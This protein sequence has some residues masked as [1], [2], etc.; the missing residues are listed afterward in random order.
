M[1]IDFGRAARGIATGYL[2]A[3]VAD[4]AAQD[5]LN[6]EFILQ[7]T[8][9]YFNVD[10]P[11]FVAD[12]K[13][14]SANI[15]FIATKLSPVYANYADA[16]NITLSDVNTR[17]FISSIND[18]SNEDKFKLESTITQRKKTRTQTFDEKNKFITDQ[19]ANL[20]GGPGSMNIT[21]MF[22]PNEGQDIAEVGVKQDVAPTTEM[23]SIMEIEGTGGMYDFNNT[24]HR[25][26]ERIGAT[27]FNQLFFDRNTQRF[28]FAI[29]GDKN[30]QGDFVDS[31]YPTVQLLKQGYADAVKQGYE[32]GFEV[33]ARDKF[34]QLVMD[35]RGIKG[36]TG[37]LP[38]EAPAVEAG[39]TEA[40]ATTTETKAVPEDNKKFDAPDTS[41]IGVK[42]DAKINIL[43]K[44]PLEGGGFGSAAT[45]I[46]DLR[47]II[48]RISDSPSLSDDEKS[49]RID[50]ARSRAKERLEA[51]GLDPDNFNL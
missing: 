13:K 49:K 37:T 20:K 38:P 27:Q 11:N 1:A 8:N 28:N 40:A 32:F 48:A 4:T 30:K 46:N 33:Y 19:F 45:V 22:F 50:I 9:Q 41:Q 39:T 35:S 31:R 16:N 44:R 17:D 43:S 21:S 15:D 14:R 24:A 6:R 3:K 10:K 42:E 36:Y 25:Q 7:A 51:M 2:S 47:D 5:E 12:E 23:K 34:I 26:L 18:L 29:S